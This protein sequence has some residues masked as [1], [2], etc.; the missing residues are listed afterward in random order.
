M[1]KLT[2]KNKKIIEL[3]VN[4]APVSFYDVNNGNTIGA[5]SFL[6]KAIEVLAGDNADLLGEA[7]ISQ[8][9]IDTKN[10]SKPETRAIAS[11]EV[12]LNSTMENEGQQALPYGDEPF[13]Y[14]A[15]LSSGEI[16][17]WLTTSLNKAEGKLYAIRAISR[18]I[19]GLMT[20]LGSLDVNLEKE[21]FVHHPDSNLKR[22][23]SQCHHLS[24][25]AL[26]FLSQSGLTKGDFPAEGLSVEQ[27][28]CILTKCQKAHE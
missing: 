14:T 21:S 7:I 12:A 13:I 27:K 26:F 19:D 11:G 3:V 25:L 4:G 5:L 23:L 24:Q 22:D 9:T 8:F 10:I 6:N 15:N 16:V 18:G 28:Q 2:R 1:S 20:Q 17:D